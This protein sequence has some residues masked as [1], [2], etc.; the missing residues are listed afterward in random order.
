MRGATKRL[1]SYDPFEK[2]SIHAPHARGDLPQMVQCFI[3]G[4]FNPRPSCEGRLDGKTTLAREK[5]F[6]STPLMRGATFG[7]WIR[8]FSVRISIHAPHARGDSSLLDTKKSIMNF[9]P[10][11]SCEGRQQNVTITEQVLHIT[12]AMCHYSFFSFIQYGKK[13]HL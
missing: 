13:C 6:Q 5:L 9:N 2:I 1:L 11:P 12:H 10:R 8:D 7:D 4:Y 3:R